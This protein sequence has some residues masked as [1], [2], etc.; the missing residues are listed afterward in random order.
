MASQSQVVVDTAH[1]GDLLDAVLDYYGRRLATCS[2]DRTIKIFDVGQPGT[3]STGANG[4]NTVGT[5]IGASG[6][7]GHGQQHLIDTLRGHDGPVWQLSW[8]HPK[9]GTILASSGYDGK[10]I[11]WREQ[12]GQWS[13]LV[14]HAL[15]TASVN[16]VAWGPHE[17]GAVLAAASSDGKVSIAE[18][19]DDGSW[20][21]RL[22][23]AHPLGCNAVSWAPSSVPGSLISATGRVATDSSSSSTSPTAPVRRIVTAG[24]DNLAKIWRYDTASSNWLEEK[25]LEGHTDWVRDVSWAPNIGLPKQY[26][27]TAGQ[28]KV[29]YVW[30]QLPGEDWKRTNLR[31]NSKNNADGDSQQQQQQQQQY[32]PDVVWRVSWSESGN[33]LAVSCG[34]GKIYVYKEEPTGWTEVS[35]VTQ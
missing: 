4:N 10:V 21:T 18:F 5:A 32:F 1:Q 12:G 28:D 33:L 22:I 7:H 15:H 19:K 26:V 11:V 17:V 30:T 3:G 31:H 9:F 34:D 14:E 13:N 16:G 23:N 20:D 25:T 27:A 35:Q 6:G 29:V 2:S 8:A 24:C